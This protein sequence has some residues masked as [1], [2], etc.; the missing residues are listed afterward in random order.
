MSFANATVYQAVG[1]PFVAPDGLEVL[2]AIVKATFE[3]TA[4]GQL[5]LALSQEPVRL[6]DEILNPEAMDSSITRPSDVCVRKVGTDVVVFG[7]AVSPEPVESLD[8]AVHI[9]DR[10]TALRVHGDRIY[11]RGVGGV[12]VGPAAPFTRK[13]IVY[14]RAYGGAT[15]D[16]A[17]VDRNNPVGRGVCREEGE[18]VGRP[19]PQIEDPA[20]PITGAGDRPEPVGFG[21]I[22]PAWSPR[23]ELAGTFDEAWFR[24]RRP[25]L[26]VDYHPR[27]G[28]LAHPRLQFDDPL[29]PGE[30]VRLLG[31]SPHGPW[32]ARLPEVPVTVAARFR[33]GS[34]ERIRPPIDTVFIEPDRERIEL[35]LRAVFAIGRG[36]RLL[37][38]VRVD[39]GL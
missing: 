29:R 28:N 22:P 1:V 34:A 26:P 8:V 9:R 38:E 19:A 36:R 6:N 35:T 30:T 27:H 31:M 23:R 15:E 37:E 16:W 17:V 7:D 3:R 18:L 13:T 33:D 20:H 4:G 25:L 14:E 32:E 11:Y 5:A 10:V 2:I 24:E 12:R 21:A 39:N